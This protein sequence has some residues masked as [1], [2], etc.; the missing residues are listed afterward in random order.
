MLSMHMFFSQLGIMCANLKWISK[1]NKSGW[2]F[3]PLRCVPKYRIWPQLKIGKTQRVLVGSIWI[4]SKCRA[5]CLRDSASARLYLKNKAKKKSLRYLSQSAECFF[6]V[7]HPLL[8]CA[9][10]KVTYAL[11][12]AV[13]PS[14]DPG[15]SLEYVI[16]HL[17]HDNEM[18][19][20]L[21]VLK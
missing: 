17:E 19:G 10:I 20:G 12:S 2:I 14:S 21:G 5:V 13:I 18:I 7:D 4:M 6:P 11:Y 15:A 1:T 16:T 9:Q 3:N 8:I